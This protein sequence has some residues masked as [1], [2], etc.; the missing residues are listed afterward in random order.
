MRIANLI[1]EKSIR[2]IEQKMVSS[3]SLHRHH[4]GPSLV[5][6][7]PP[8]PE[9]SWDVVPWVFPTPPLSFCSLLLQLTVMLF[10]KNVLKKR[11]KNRKKE[12][13]WKTESIKYNDRNKF[14][15]I[16]SHKKCNWIKFTSFEKR[17]SQIPVFKR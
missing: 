4:S 7:R 6:P 16:N 3:R 9:G 10:N 11:K 8:T 12:K 13:A 14:K 15:H 5:C 17:D 2:K 1:T